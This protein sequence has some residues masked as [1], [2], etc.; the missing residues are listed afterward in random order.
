[1]TQNDLIAFALLE[2]AA[3]EYQL[4]Q[5]VVALRRRIEELEADSATKRKRKP[6][7]DQPTPSRVARV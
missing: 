7:S 3:R 6:N 1:M 2:A 5:E 4:Q